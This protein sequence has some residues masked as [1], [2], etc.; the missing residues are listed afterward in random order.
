MKRKL[1]IA[2]TLSNYLIDRTGTPKVVMSHQVSANDAGIKYVV[3]FPVGGSSEFTMR[4][5]SDSFGVICDGEF[6]GVFSLETFLARVGRLLDDGYELGCIYIHHLMGW[7]LGSIV[8]IVSSYPKVRLVV[9]AHDYYLCC[10]N[11]NLMQDS[12]LLC[13]SA[14]LG[15]AQCSRCS[16]YADSIIREDHI[17]RLLHSELHRIVFVCPS[18]VV[19]RMVQSFHPETKGHCMVIPHQKYVGM[20]LGNKEMLPS[21]QVIKV[22]YLG[23]QQPIKGWDCWRRLFDAFCGQGKYEFVVFNNETTPL[24]DGMRRV[25]VEFSPEKPNAMI[26]A[27]RRENVDAAFLWSQ[28]PETYSYTCMEAYASNAFIFT[29]PSSGNIAEFVSIMHCGQVFSS[30]K[31][32][33][34]LFDDPERLLE[35]LNGFRAKRDG[36]AMTLATNDAFIDLA[37]PTTPTA[38][39]SFEN[40]RRCRIRR[41]RLGNCFSVPLRALYS[42]RER[43]KIETVN[44]RK[45]KRELPYE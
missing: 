31:E 27:L 26:D 45:R 43:K 19:E 14:R 28:C 35:L 25:F 38:P 5:F 9:Y 23:K 11:Y 18:S 40:E 34:Q 10:T 24:P 4:L 22:A 8:G 32:L 21:D 44:S 1:F 29:C 20:Y 7:N 6:V 42:Y 3:L 36:G 2:I 39:N 37:K 41:F 33:C 13:G 16:H 12:G 30:E 17:W 15:D